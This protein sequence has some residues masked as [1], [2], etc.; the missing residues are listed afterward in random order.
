MEQKTSFRVSPLHWLRKRIFLFRS[1]WL[2][3]IEF[4]ALV[5]LIVWL[6]ALSTSRLGYNWQWYRVPR[7]L[8]RIREGRFIAGQLLQGLAFTFRISGVSLVLALAIGLITALVRLSASFM[9]KIVARVYLEMIRNTPLV[10]A[11]APGT[12]R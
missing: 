1:P 4:A 6:M 9:G 12:G 7:Y 3:I 11:P 5:A 2:D 10:V 8:Y